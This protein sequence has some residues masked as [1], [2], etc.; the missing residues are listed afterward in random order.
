VVLSSNG[1]ERDGRRDQMAAARRMR[2]VHCRSVLYDARQVEGLERRGRSVVSTDEDWD[3]WSR[4]AVVIRSP[5]GA[6]WRN[7]KA[8]SCDEWSSR[9]TFCDTES[10]KKW[11]MRRHHKNVFASKL[12]VMFSG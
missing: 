11:L 3:N 9:R 8:L 6:F 5:W 1:L 2:P 12:N 10:A 7:V 4:V